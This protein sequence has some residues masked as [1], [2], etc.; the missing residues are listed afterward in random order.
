MSGATDTGLMQQHWSAWW[1]C[2]LETR[3]SADMERLLN[4]NG[5]RF[6]SLQDRQA[7]NARGVQG[8]VNEQ[9]KNNLLTRCLKN[10]Q[11]EAR[12]NKENAEFNRKLDSKRKQLNS[13]QQLFKEFARQLEEGLG[14]VDGD[15]SGRGS[16][17]SRKGMKGGNT[18]AVSLPAIHK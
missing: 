8:R 11:I 10:W 7:N 4:D 1:G 15:S 6:K 3:K 12:V 2:V 16:V 9:M 14:G 13:V 5:G 17:K 18:G